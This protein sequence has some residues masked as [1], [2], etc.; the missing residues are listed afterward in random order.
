MMSAMRGF[1]A[2]REES[3]E[4]IDTLKEAVN[5]ELKRYSR[6]LK[7]YLGSSS[8]NGFSGSFQIAIIINRQYKRLN[9]R[10]T[11]DVDSHIEIHKVILSDYCAAG[12]KKG[13][14]EYEILNN[15]LVLKGI[16]KLLTIPLPVNLST[17]VLN[18]LEKEKEIYPLTCPCS[19]SIVSRKDTF[20][21]LIERI[22]SYFKKQVAK[23]A[24][25]HELVGANEITATSEQE[26]RDEPVPENDRRPKVGYYTPSKPK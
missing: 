13:D 10:S 15:Y 2:G 8:V 5:A 22:E 9:E 1:F 12:L 20:E 11:K 7:N 23:S 26:E 25:T 16:Q 17:Q 3:P 21:K 4:S 6:Y 18:L 14:T 24:T 19:K